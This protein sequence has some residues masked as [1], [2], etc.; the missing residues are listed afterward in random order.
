MRVM[1]PCHLLKGSPSSGCS[2]RRDSVR[3]YGVLASVLELLHAYP[4]WWLLA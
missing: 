3:N 4:A 2:S 1:S